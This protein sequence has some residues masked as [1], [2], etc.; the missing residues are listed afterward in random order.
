MATRTRVQKA[1]AK[2]APRPAKKL[3]KKAA[4]K[5]AATKKAPPKKAAPKTAPAERK[6]RGPLAAFGGRELELS[7]PKLGALS[8]GIAHIWRE[9]EV[10]LTAD[11]D[12]LVVLGTNAAGLW[13]VLAPDGMIHLIDDAE[14]EL[15]TIL[16]PSVA[17]FAK[18]LA[19]QN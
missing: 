8:P 14:R 1:P 6:A 18:E 11:G 13:F 5:K 16:F 3:A 7:L 9:P 4:P 2:R 19:R 17:A 10:E 12:E 15:G